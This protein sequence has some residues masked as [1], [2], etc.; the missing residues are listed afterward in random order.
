MVEKFDEMQLLKYLFILE[1][2]SDL[3][4][5]TINDLLSTLDYSQPV[6]EIVLNDFMEMHIVSKKII[7][8]FSPHLYYFFTADSP[9]LVKY[10]EV[11]G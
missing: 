2:I 11:T 8:A 4:Y 1:K 7:S 5:F 3:I 6:F 9:S 10:F